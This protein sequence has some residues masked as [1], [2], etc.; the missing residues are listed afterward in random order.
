MAPRT[1]EQIF[2]GFAL[3]GLG[4]YANYK[5][6]WG[7]ELIGFP[8]PWAVVAVGIVMLL[9]N[10]CGFVGTNKR[11]R[12]CLLLYF[13]FL[14]FIMAAEVSISILAL[15]YK[16]N[17]EEQ[18]YQ[19]WLDAS[20]ETKDKVQRKFNCCGFYTV[21]DNPGPSCTNPPAGTDSCAVAITKWV[22]EKLVFVYIVGFLSAAVQVF[23]L[24]AALVLTKR[25]DD[26]KKGLEASF[27]YYYYDDND[28][29]IVDG[30]AG[31]NM[32]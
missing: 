6:S 11:K 12:T 29:L 3:V 14:F 25:I 2:V 4:I 20:P 7:E 23:C 28:Q 10:T 21:N 8:L 24:V 9:L 17:L 18:L 19:G 16:R 22:E 30:P 5:Y 26:Y 1:P 31:R 15:S 13:T 27:S 32:I